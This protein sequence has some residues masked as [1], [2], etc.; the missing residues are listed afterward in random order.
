ME[1]DWDKCYE[2]FDV[3][4]KESN[5]S[6]AVYAYLRAMALYMKSG[7]DE[8]QLQKVQEEMKMVDA[9]KKKIAGKSIP[10]EVQENLLD[11]PW[12]HSSAYDIDLFL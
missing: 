8:K 4:R 6:K 10:M 7:N 11:F 1:R 9:S 3:L 5:W 2:L 12:W